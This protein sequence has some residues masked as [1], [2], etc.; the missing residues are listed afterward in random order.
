MLT[1]SRGVYYAGRNFANFLSEVHIRYSVGAKLQWNPAEQFEAE[2]DE[3]VTESP[4]MS[5]HELSIKFCL[6]HVMKVISY[7]SRSKRVPA[8]GPIPSRAVLSD[9]FRF[10]AFARRSA[11]RRRRDAGRRCKSWV[12]YLFLLASCYYQ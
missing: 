4:Y 9:T 6:E 2:R 7:I 1:L 12:S 11:Q 8:G 10:G 5:L 3:K